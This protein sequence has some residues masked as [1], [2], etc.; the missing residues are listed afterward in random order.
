MDIFLN[1]ENFEK[2]KVMQNERVF[3][4]DSKYVIRILEIFFNDREKCTSRVQK[5]PY[6]TSLPGYKDLGLSPKVRVHMGKLK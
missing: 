2:T 1:I 4:A 3:N 5:C 6:F